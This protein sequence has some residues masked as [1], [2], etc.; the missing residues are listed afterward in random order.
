MSNTTPGGR[1]RVASLALVV[2]LAIAG[3]SLTACRS[4]DRESTGAGSGSS[5]SQTPTPAPTPSPDIA[6]M[7]ADRMAETLDREDA[8]QREL[9]ERFAGVPADRVE[10]QLA[11]EQRE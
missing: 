11:A 10:E 4:G 8:R 3:G 2:V 1:T 9:S 7:T 5:T 6:G